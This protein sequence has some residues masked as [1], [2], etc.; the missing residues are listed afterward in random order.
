MMYC[1]INRFWS[2]HILKEGDYKGLERRLVILHPEHSTSDATMITYDTAICVQFK[3]GKFDMS[4]MACFCSH[5]KRGHYRAGSIDCIV[6]SFSSCPG[7]GSQHL[8]LP[9]V[10]F[11]KEHDDGVRYFDVPNW[12]Q[13]PVKVLYDAEEG[14]LLSTMQPSK[15]FSDLCTHMQLPEVPVLKSNREPYVEERITQFWANYYVDLA[16]WIEQADRLNVKR[17][18][19]CGVLWQH[20]CFGKAPHTAAAAKV[21]EWDRLLASM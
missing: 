14:D 1:T 13:V 7:A 18:V 12:I 4:S 15:W 11:L 9:A 8:I 16:V 21:A 5:V 20:Y 3:C 6:I 19:Y 17:H 10:D 2:Q